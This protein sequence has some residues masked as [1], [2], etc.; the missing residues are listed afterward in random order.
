MISV[1]AKISVSIGT[2]INLDGIT[3]FYKNNISSDIS[4][5]IGKKYESQNPFI[6]GSSDLSLGA[7]LV[8]DTIPYFI[9][10]DLCDDD[11]QFFSPYIMT[12]SGDEEFSYLT[13]VFGTYNN[14]HPNTINV[15]GQNFEVSSS[16]VILS[17]E[18]STSHIVSISDWNTPNSP[19]V[20]QGITPDAELDI[21][22]NS[23]LNIEF[24][25]RDRTDP[26][27]ISWGIVSNT[28]T[29][30]FLD[31]NKYV[32]NLK[33]NGDLLGSKIEIYLR[34]R[35]RDAQIGSFIVTDG[36]YSKCGGSSTLRFQDRLQ[37]WQNVTIP[38]DFVLSFS[39]MTL[40]NIRY[41][42][43]T[44]VKGLDIVTHYTSEAETRWNGTWV[45][46]PYVIGSS[47]WSFMA[48]A[49]ELTGCYI[50]CDEKGRA[51]IAYGGGT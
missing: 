51:V 3:N 40:E 48:K 17:F 36:V 41:A 30:S 14:Q 16:I 21:D 6:L 13:L 5:C 24:S 11:G 25:G 37:E 18:S 38:E 8:D 27:T 44:K 4:A 9:S 2:K 26:T 39:P 33:K 50:S 29:V 15:D 47:F 19:L 49:C 31:N 35:Y 10:G 34:N 32:E 23:L 28:G 22:K 45:K 42:I 43:T 1:M 7:E 46:N 12:I 20:I